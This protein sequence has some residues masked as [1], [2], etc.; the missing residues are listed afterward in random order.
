[1]HRESPAP[2]AGAAPQEPR[3]APPVAREGALCNLAPGFAGGKDVFEG[4]PRRR[5]P[6]SRVRGPNPCLLLERLPPSL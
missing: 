5:S 6:Q 1:M 2:E 3:I 4:R